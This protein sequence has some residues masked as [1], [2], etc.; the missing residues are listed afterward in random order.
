MAVEEAISGPA[1][2]REEKWRAGVLQA[3]RDLDGKISEHIESTESPDGVLA[4]IMEEAPRLAH[5][6]Q[7]LQDEHP[8]M[9]EKTRAL[10]AR[11][12][13]EALSDEGWSVAEARDE[14]QRLLG[15]LVKHRQLG[16]DVIWEAYNLD[17]GGIG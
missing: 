2:G 1:S 15:L 11:L 7:R 9:Q 17:I 13:S 6:I 16:A 3:L 5:K 14:T 4:Q 12:E 8:V 10:I